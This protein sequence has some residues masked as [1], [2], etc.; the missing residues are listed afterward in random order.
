MCACGNPIILTTRSGMP[1]HADGYWEILVMHICTHTIFWKLELGMILKIFW[2]TSSP[3]TADC[4]INKDV[5]GRGYA[6]SYDIYC[7]E[8]WCE[9]HSSH[10]VSCPQQFWTPVVTGHWIIGLSKNP[11]SGF[12]TICVHGKKVSVVAVCSGGGVIGSGGGGWPSKRY[13]PLSSSCQIFEAGNIFCW[14]GKL[15]LLRRERKQN[16]SLV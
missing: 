4:V 14:K 15:D 16:S 2:N 11:W 10:C 13:F 3:C 1:A 6:P 9:L 12:W 7:I 5:W 8:L